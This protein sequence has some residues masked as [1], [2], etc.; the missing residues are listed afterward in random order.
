M[1]DQRDIRLLELQ[2]MQVRSEATAARLEA[3]A[4]E[5]ELTLQRLGI[6]RP[7]SEDESPCL[8]DW[9]TLSAL[10][11]GAPSPNSVSLRPI[12][13]HDSKAGSVPSAA[14]STG[15]PARLPSQVRQQRRAHN[16]PSTGAPVRS[17]AT[18]PA[19]GSRRSAVLFSGMIHG[20]LLLALA[21]VSL[22]L[23]RPMDQVSLTAVAVESALEPITAVSIETAEPTVDTTQPSEAEVEVNLDQLAE[24]SPVEIKP[25]ESSLPPLESLMNSGS[26]TAALA[27]LQQQSSSLGEKITFCGVE[28]GGNHFVYLVDCS[29]SM[30]KAFESARSELLRSI[31]ALKPEQ[32]FYVIFFDASPDYMRV[33]NA[34]VDDPQSV[35]AS[36]E[37]KRS[38]RRWAT[39]VQMDNGAAPYAPLEFALGLRPD[40][41]FL[42]SDGEF[43]AGIEELLRK[44]NRVENLF[45]EVQVQSIVHTISYHSQEGERRMQSIASQNQ[46][47]YRHIPKPLP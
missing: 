41:I 29:K 10:Q 42:L 2:L 7:G 3:R 36:P 30:G 32:R 31:D 22:Q 16:A 15:A 12:V 21:L 40:V 35:L 6:A 24:V 11:R 4:A 37:H 13:A 20:G 34:N 44:Q 46:G 26:S 39:G 38:L 1:V 28:G 33:G 14:P 27:A 47:Q 5:I 8:L 23:P 9:E 18:R 17:P 45:G 25:G 19:K 43:P